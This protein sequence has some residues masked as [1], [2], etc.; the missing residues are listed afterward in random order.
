MALNQSLA[1]LMAVGIGGFLAWR[2]F[3]VITTRAKKAAGLGPADL[4]SRLNRTFNG[5]PQVTWKI[6]GGGIYLENLIAAATSRGYR[7][8]TENGG[9]AIFERTS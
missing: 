9:V 5:A 4:Q 2:L 1:V 3:V 8:V 6:R 7:F